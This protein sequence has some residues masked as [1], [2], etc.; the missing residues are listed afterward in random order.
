MEFNTDLSCSRTTGLDMVLNSS[1]GLVVTM[2]PGYPDYHGP[3]DSVTPGYQHGLQWWSG[4]LESVW[5]LMAT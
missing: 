1:L 2:A 3:S 5:P 4:P